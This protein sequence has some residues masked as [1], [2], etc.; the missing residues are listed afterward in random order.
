MVKLPHER[1]TRRPQPSALG[2]NQDMPRRLRGISLKGT[3]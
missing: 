1:A 3:E 2:I